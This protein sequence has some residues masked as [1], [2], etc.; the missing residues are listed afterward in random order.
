MDNELVDAIRIP[1]EASDANVQKKLNQ[2]YNKEGTRDKLKETRQ[3][4]LTMNEEDSFNAVLSV[5]K[6]SIHI[7]NQFK[8]NLFKSLKEDDQYRDL[9]QKLEDPEH[10]NEISI[11]DQVFRI[12]QGTL[13]VHEKN[14][15][16][17]ANYWRT[18]GPNEISIKQMILCEL[19]CVP[20]AGHPGFIRPLQIVKQFFYWTYMT[21]DVRE[22]VLDSPV[23]QVEKGSHLKP[24]VQLQSL[25]LLVRKWDH[26]VLD[27]VLGMPK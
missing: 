4:I 5:S 14:Q 23:C 1:V 16:N 10:P 22:F 18:V 15:A 19:H 20:Y 11:N 7:D 25:E 13:K 21:A 27:F 9:I 6:S 2:L 26:V 8:Q 17:A 24:G 12:K 3:Q